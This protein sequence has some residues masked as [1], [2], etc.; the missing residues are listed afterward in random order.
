MGAAFVTLG[1]ALVDAVAIGL[2][3]HDE[4]AAVGGSG[5][6]GGNK[7]AAGKE[8]GGKSHDG[9]RQG[10]RTAVRTRPKGLIMINHEGRA[11]AKR[12]VP[13]PDR[14]Q[15]GR[16][17]GLDGILPIPQWWNHERS[18]RHLQHLPRDY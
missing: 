11:A 5:R 18:P 7:E 14:P 13:Q 17:Q 15:I 2:I 16:K 12:K 3:G 4:D 6:E 10:R 8:R 1:E 9:H